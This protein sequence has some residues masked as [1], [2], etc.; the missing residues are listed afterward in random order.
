MRAGDPA[1]H[2]DDGDENEAE[3]QRDVERSAPS[4]DHH[5]AETEEYEHEGADEFGDGFVH[6]DTPPW[7]TRT[8]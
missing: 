4:T 7:D 5:G 8:C 6:W 1:D 3:R 2:G